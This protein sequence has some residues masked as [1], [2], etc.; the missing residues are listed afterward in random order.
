MVTPKLTAFA[1][2][3]GLAATALHAQDLR[4]GLQED[5][6]VLDPDQSRTFVGRIVYAS[7]C[8]KLV[9]ITPDLEIIPQLATGWEWSDDGLQLTMTLRE[10]AVFHDGTPFNAE[11]VAANI[12]RS[13]NLPESRRK[14]EL[15]SITGVEVV[16]DMTI[17]FTLGAP[18]ATLLAQF[19]DRAGMMLS[20]TAFEAAGTDLG[21][22]PV[23]SGPF[24]FGERI[25]QDR[26]VLNRF[27]DYWNADAINVDSVTFL[28]IPDTTVRL[29]NLRAGDLDMLERLAA[30]D[31]ASVNN[32]EDLQLEQA[33]SLGYQGITINVNN[34]AGADNPLGQDARIRQALSLAIDRNVINQVVFEGAFAP[35][36]QPFPPTSPWY[37][38]AY[39]VPER[40]VE[41]ARALLAEAGF[42]D[43]IDITIQVTNNP[44]QLQ[45]MQVVQSMASEAGINLELQAKEF[46]TLLA[47]QSAGDY[48]ASQI[49]W[50]GR[51]DPDGNIHQFMTT[52]GGINDS[53]YSNPEVDRLLNEARTSTDMAVRQASYNAA[54]DILIQDLPIV[55]LYHPT[56]IWALSNS[57]EGFTPYPDGMIR[58]EG[59]TLSE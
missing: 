59:V 37:N 3:F 27:A 43:G 7:L 10:G 13:Q 16:D 1:L 32:D 39:P 30:T 15:S 56:W 48:T 11:A 26:I 28:P 51:V 2:A 45:M 40:D 5:P 44:V 55:Y 12:D 54:R 23:C 33:V 36:N 14:S 49:G 42:A 25:Q 53:G 47:D 22:N 50:S 57:V 35:G 24:S 6:D 21:L 29:A 8:D 18:D 20:P 41:A 46:A 9:D 31:V 52:D 17:R 19:A 58:L 4:I 34:G 38:D